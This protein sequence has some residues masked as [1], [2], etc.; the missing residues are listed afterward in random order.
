VDVDLW[1]KSGPPSKLDLRPEKVKF[2]EMFGLT[3]HTKKNCKW[4]R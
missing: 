1:I 3:T 4:G 2:L